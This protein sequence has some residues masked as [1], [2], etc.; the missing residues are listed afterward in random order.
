MRFHSCK[1]GIIGICILICGM[2]GCNLLEKPNWTLEEAMDSPVEL[3]A[4]RMASDAVVLEIAFIH[5]NPEDI[6]A[7]APLWVD[8][9]ENHV[10]IQL[11]GQLNDNGIRCGLIGGMIPES[12]LQLISA[13][14]NQVDH[15]NIPEH[16]KQSGHARNMRMQF[17][18]GR[19][20]KIVMSNHQQDEMKIVQVDGDYITGSAFNQAQATFTV[21]TYPKGDGRVEIELTPE[22]HHGQP[23]SNFIGHDGSWLVQTE[24][25]VTAFENLIT[26]NILSPGET[27]LLT[28]TPDSKGLGGHFF[29]TGPSRNDTHYVLLIRLAQ[30]QADDLFESES[31]SESLAT[32]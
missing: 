6:A 9:D 19:E 11:R 10:P 18:H 1:L 5:V 25:E 22:I 29:S 7:T 20:G 14:K 28:S 15:E 26:R 12:V 21:R 8:I 24:R 30:T 27:L 17:R 23:K 13:E 32:H 3:N 2:T 4:P 31:S 16:V